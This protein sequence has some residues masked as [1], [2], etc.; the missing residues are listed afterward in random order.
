MYFSLIKIACSP[1]SDGACFD[2]RT[3]FDPR[4]SVVRRALAAVAP[5]TRTSYLRTIRARLG[6][7]P[8]RTRPQAQ[9]PCAVFRA[10][11]QARSGGASAATR[12]R[13]RCVPERRKG[14]SLTM[15]SHTWYLHRVPSVTAA[16]IVKRRA[17]HVRRGPQVPRSR[18]FFLNRLSRGAF[19]AQQAERTSSRA[20]RRSICPPSGQPR[21]A[22]VQRVIEALS[23]H[24][25]EPLGVCGPL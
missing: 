21:D 18:R 4:I 2:R 23:V 12:A 15:T 10:Q 16:C 22:R 11:R 5:A 24:V 6:G 1:R 3:G 25:R 8:R 9:P 7:T 20:P 17:L 13:H 19:S 14:P